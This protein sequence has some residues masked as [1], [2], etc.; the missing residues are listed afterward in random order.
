VIEITV[1]AG[2][3]EPV[4][5]EAGGCTV[6]SFHLPKPDT[7]QAT[8]E[9]TG[10]VGRLLAVLSEPRSSTWSRPSKPASSSAR[11]PTN[12]TV[13]SRTEAERR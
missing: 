10:E 2:K 3:P 1:A 8:G 13:A 12:P 6:V 4:F 7:P 5:A 9:V 11:S